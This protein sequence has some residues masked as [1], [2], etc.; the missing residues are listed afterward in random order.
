MLRKAF[1]ESSFCQADVVFPYRVFVGRYVG[2]VDY[3]S[4]EAVVVQWAFFIFSAVAYV[5]G[6]G[7]GALVR[8]FFVVF[9]NYGLHI[10]RV[11]VA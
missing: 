1:L 7:D 6:G 11:A 2:V 4:S 10:F 3:T 5:V 9:A 8:Y